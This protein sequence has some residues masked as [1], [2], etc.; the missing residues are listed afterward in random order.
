MRYELT[1]LSC[2][3][4]GMADASAGARAWV[5]GA[6][7]GKLLGIWRSDIGRIGQLMVLR[8]FDTDAD[9]VRERERALMSENPFGS[10][11]GNTPLTMESYAPFP[12]LP[13]IEPRDY[14]GTFEFRT[15]Y[16]R[17]GGLPGTLAGLACC[18]FDGQSVR[19]MRPVS[20]TR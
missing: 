3:P 8:S 16:Q 20:R 17:P 14:G 7:A 13:N 9:M 2:S 15:Y 11:S 5:A 19:L 18:R 12:F 10:A 1:T 6:I 4:L